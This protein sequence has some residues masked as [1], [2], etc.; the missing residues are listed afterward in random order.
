MQDIYAC[1]HRTLKKKGSYKGLTFNT[2]EQM[3]TENK[4][5]AG[6]KNVRVN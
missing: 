3:K 6:E 1:R 4:T 5:F 2:I